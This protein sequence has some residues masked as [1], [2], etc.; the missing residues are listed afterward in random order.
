MMP[1]PHLAAHVNVYA[2]NLAR[3]RK[4]ALRDAGIILGAHRHLLMMAGLY[5][6]IAFFPGV[7]GYQIPPLTVVTPFMFTMAAICALLLPV[8][9]I[10]GGLAL[11][12]AHVLLTLALFITME[13]AAL[14]IKA[15]LATIS[16][17]SWDD[18]LARMDRMLFLGAHPW[19]LLQPLAGHPGI[20]LMLDATYKLWMAV[21][22]ASWFFAAFGMRHDDLR[23]RYLLAFFL[24]WALGGNLLAYVLSSAGPAFLEHLGAD[25]ASAYA[26]L[27][28]YLKTVDS[29]RSLTAVHLQTLLWQQYLAGH[30]DLG[31]ISAFP[32]MHNALAALMALAAWR[33]HRGLGILLTVFTLLIFAGSIL[34]AWHYAVDGIAGIAMALFCWHLAGRIAQHLD[35]LPEIR[36]YRA[37]LRATADG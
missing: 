20:T 29:E 23:I 36:R 31:G 21:L 9:V 19:R 10:S 30:N 35:R 8:A 24:T 11:R 27:I 14:G 17:W 26:D 5:L 33:V 16:P 28:S 12:I 6:G 2:A 37:L 25:A 32:S 3:L 34:L 1:I 4:H 7:L 15:N 18:T 13:F 22:I